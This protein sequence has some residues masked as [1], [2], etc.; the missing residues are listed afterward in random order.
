MVQTLSER[1]SKVHSGTIDPSEDNMLKIT[2]DGRKLGLDQRIINQLLPDEPGTK[3]NQCI[4]N[5]VQ[6]WRDGEADKL[7][8]LVF[9]DI[10]TP[11]AA[12]S[13]KVAKALDNPTLHALEEAIPLPDAEPAFTI[14]ED[15]RQKLIAQGMPADQIAFIHEAKTE[16]QKKELFSKVRTG[17]VRVLLG[18]TAKMG[19]GTN[20][21]D[22][23]V[24]LHDLDCP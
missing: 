6:I 5:I 11:Q 18:S 22:R 9:C 17:Q 23:L 10:S 2:G 13:Q 24:A 19:A 8:Q 16:V 21:Q 7:T 1:A 3:V 20:V 14:Y 4:N 12:P 15:I